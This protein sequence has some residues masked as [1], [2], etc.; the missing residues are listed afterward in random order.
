M[1]QLFLLNVVPLSACKLAI[2]VAGILSFQEVE[3][4]NSEGVQHQCECE[5]DSRTLINLHFLCTLFY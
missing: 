4:C 5:Q 2:H 1:Y 3:A